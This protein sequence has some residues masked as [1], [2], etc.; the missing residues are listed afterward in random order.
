MNL[1]KHPRVLILSYTTRSL[2]T[3]PFK[4]KVII[5]IERNVS[6]HC[7]TGL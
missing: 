4:D 2:L 5:N 6:Y 1:F 3:I 7:F